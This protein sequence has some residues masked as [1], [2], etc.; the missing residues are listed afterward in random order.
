MKYVPEPKGV[1]SKE[2]KEAVKK[3]RYE[4]SLDWLLREGIV[5]IC[6][7]CHNRL[8]IFDNDYSLTAERDWQLDEG[9]TE[10]LRN[11]FTEKGI[12]KR[13]MV[14]ANCSEADDAGDEFFV[15][16]DCAEQGVW[17][18]EKSADWPI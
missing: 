7:R 10:E 15:C 14:Y 6:P 13:Y 9:A 1:M 5:T 12:Q 11:E 4:T 2:A 18:G 17:V 3:L 8:I 16:E